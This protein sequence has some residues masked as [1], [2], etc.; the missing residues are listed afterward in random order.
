LVRMS[1]LGRPVVQIGTGEELG[2]DEKPRYSNLKP[3]LS[4][5]TVTL[6]SALSSF[7]LPK[8]L[9]EKD[10]KEISVNTGRY[11]PYVKFG[12]AFISLPRF[13]DPF[14]MTLEKAIPLIDAKIEAD[15]PLSYFE[16][17]PITKG[18][19]KFGPFIKWTT[20]YVN[21]PKAYN[22]DT[23]TEPQAHELLMA[24][25]EK[26]ANK[27]IHHWPEENIS[28]EAG[29]WGPFIK[30]GKN[31]INLP[32]IEGAKMTVDQ[33]RTLD[34]ADVKKRILEEIP[35]AF[36]KKE[37][38]APVKKAGTAAAKKAPAKKMK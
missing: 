36:E 5:E 14:E 23:L 20:I 18:K 1:S 34:L 16:N 4:L 29:R 32:K 24:K 11:G 26:E 37:K 8:L 12:E 6:E 7:A 33:A 17:Q 9:G 28:V 21:V 31:M 30:F 3:G 38:K 25:I 13:E 19:G 2:K 10:G 15:R 27:Y 35:N 22:F